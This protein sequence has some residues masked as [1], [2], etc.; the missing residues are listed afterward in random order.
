MIG[1]GEKL[2]K[3]KPKLLILAKWWEN[4]FACHLICVCHCLFEVDIMSN[5]SEEVLHLYLSI[6]IYTG[7]LTA[8]V[9][10]DGHFEYVFL[11]GFLLS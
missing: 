2:Y 5:T 11:A 9:V 3:N 7:F 10:V 8:V 6:T 4:N 1:I